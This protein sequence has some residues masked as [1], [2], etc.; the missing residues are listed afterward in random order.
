MV[1]VDDIA[2][3]NIMAAMHG[4]DLKG[5]TFNI[6]TGSAVTNNE[7]LQMIWKAHG[8]YERQDTP[9]RSGD[10][11]HARG[12]PTKAKEAFGFETRVPF[13]VGLELTMKWWGLL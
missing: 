7:I 9:P 12:D 3:A 10:V 1:Y 8:P 13:N 2:S 4:S 5:G 6:C 11:M